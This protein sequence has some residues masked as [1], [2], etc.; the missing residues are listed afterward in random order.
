MKC[1]KILCP[2]YNGTTHTLKISIA[3]NIITNLHVPQQIITLE[4]PQD[5]GMLYS[6]C[7]TRGK[8]IACYCVGATHLWEE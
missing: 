6:H 3:F 1:G 4:R 7:V 8:H 2:K 5:T